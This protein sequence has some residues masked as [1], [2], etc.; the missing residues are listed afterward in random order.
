MP[1]ND[2]G[3]LPQPRTLRNSS[4]S[5]VSTVTRVAGGAEALEEARRSAF[6]LPV[7]DVIM[8]GMNGLVLYRTIA[9]F[10][11]ALKVLHISG[12]PAGAGFLRNL[13]NDCEHLLQ[14]P[15]T[16][17]GLLDKVHAAMDAAV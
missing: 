9:E 12:Y 4:C 1:K 11:P 10:A 13:F 17:A 8:P 14:K 2:P 5:A 15:F 6:D 3:A 16:I 7:S